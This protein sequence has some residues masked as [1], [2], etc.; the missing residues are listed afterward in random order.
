MELLD[1]NVLLHI[2]GN[3]QQIFQTLS[4]INTEFSN[5]FNIKEYW[6]RFPFLPN[7]KYKD[8]QHATCLCGAKFRIPSR[9]TRTMLIEYPIYNTTFKAEFNRISNF[10]PII[11]RE[12]ITKYKIKQTFIQFSIYS[13]N[14]CN[15]YDFH[16][17][18]YINNKVQRRNKQI[19]KY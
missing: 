13:R 16:N 10:K 14:F 11:L 17:S 4:L 2:V 3:D 15:S 7:H 19:H 12:P 1:S 8:S 6:K 18:R 5:I 9:I